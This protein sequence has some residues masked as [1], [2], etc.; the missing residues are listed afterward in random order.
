MEFDQVPVIHRSIASTPVLYNRLYSQHRSVNTDV[1]EN[2]HCIRT[3]KQ[4]YYTVCRGYPH[5]K[6]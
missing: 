4:N 6:F 1:S 2:V 5:C 3:Q